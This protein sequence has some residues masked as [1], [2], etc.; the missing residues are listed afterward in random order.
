MG[1]LASHA[2]LTA[3]TMRQAMLFGTAAA[4]FCVED[5]GARRVANLTVQDIASRV[6]GIRRL[7]DFGGTLHIPGGA[8]A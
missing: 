4:S 2:E 8:H 7:Y 1:Y 5:V 3:M 6:E